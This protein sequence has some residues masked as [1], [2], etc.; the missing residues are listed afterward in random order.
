MVLNRSG[1]RTVTF[2]KWEPEPE[3]EPY[4]FKSGT[5]TV[6]I[7]TVPQH[8]WREQGFFT[9]KPAGPARR[10]STGQ[11]TLGGQRGSVPRS[12]YLFICRTK[13]MRK[14]VF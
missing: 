11:A 14:H 5:S 12:F 2:Q 9:K 10:C 3:P 4:L 8:W 7:V 6:K 1:T 13:K